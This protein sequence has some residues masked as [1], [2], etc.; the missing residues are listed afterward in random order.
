MLDNLPRGT[1][2]IE[3]IEMGM[4]RHLHKVI[5][6]FYWLNLNGNLCRLYKT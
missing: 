5:S 3:D 2:C 6:D 4:S 1:I